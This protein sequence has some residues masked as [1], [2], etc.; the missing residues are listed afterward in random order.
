MW[1]AGKLK[2]LVLNVC[3]DCEV[4]LL[5]CFGTRRTGRSLQ[6]ATGSVSNR[7]SMPFT[8]KTLYLASEVK[9]LFAAG[10]PM[11]GDRMEMAHSAEG[12]VPFLD[13]GGPLSSSGPAS[14]SRGIDPVPTS[15]SED[16]RNDG[17]VCF[18]RVNPRRHHR[19]GLPETEASIFEPA[20]YAE[21]QREAQHVHARHTSWPYSC[22]NPHS[23]IKRRSLVFWTA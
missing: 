3:T 5:L 16:P 8:K 6:V 10:V 2:N 18:K 7:C 23:S 4:N 13:R 21:S 9:A 12:R 22:G 17:E 1:Y 20:G 19:H 15:D 14:P 11:L